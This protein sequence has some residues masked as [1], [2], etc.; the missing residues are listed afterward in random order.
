MPNPSKAPRKKK[1][2]IETSVIERNR[3]IKIRALEILRQG[4]PLMTQKEAIAIAKRQM[5]G[6]GK[7]G[8]KLRIEE[9]R[10]SSFRAR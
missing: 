4:P 2:D 8:S 1:R 3:I 6:E 9:I 10:H 7:K 5:A